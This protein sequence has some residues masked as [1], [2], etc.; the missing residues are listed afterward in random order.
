MKIILVGAA[1]TIGSHAAAELE[2]RH[3]VIRASASRGALKVDISHLSSIRSMYKHVASFDAVVCTA[4][5]AYFGPFEQM[6]EEDFYK[7]IRSKMM[8][9]INLV[10]AGID[11]INEGGSFT[12]TSGILWRDPVKG[13]AA[14]STVNSALHGFVRGASIEL[15]RDVRLNAVSPG[16][17]EDSASQLGAFFPGHTPVAM[18]RVVSGYVK[19]VEGAVTG[20][21]IEVI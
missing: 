15:K 5:S 18:Q 17:V 2:R 11:F 10:M 16:L 3:E 6:T 14:L 8:G 19:S 20:Q 9:Q 4:G 1:G 21:V 7:G 13:G 12:L